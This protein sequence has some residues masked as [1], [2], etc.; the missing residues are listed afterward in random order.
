[1]KIETDMMLLRSAFLAG[2]SLIIGVAAM[3]PAH[4]QAVVIGVN[5]ANPQRLS[6]VEQDKVLDQLQA[7][8]VRVIRAPLKPAFGDHDYGAAIDFLHLAY[9]RGIKT[10]LIIGLQYRES[11]QRR[12][13]ARDMPDMW[14]SYPLSSADPIRFR[15]V[16]QPLFAQL[17]ALGIHFVSLELGNEINGTAFNGDFPIPG[18]G[19]VFGIDDLAQDP[20]ARQIAAGFLAYLQTL[21]VL[22]DIRDHSRLNRTTPIL[23][24]GLS[25]PGPAGPRP[26]SKV[27]AVTISATLDFLRANGLDTLVD[28][29]GVHAYPWADN[30]ARRLN[31]LERDTL[32][33]CRPSGQGKPCWLTEWGIPSDDTSCP[34]NDAPRTA[35]MREILA[36]FRPFA[37]RGRLKGLLYYAWTDDKYGIYRCASLA[38]SGRLVL[39]ASI[40]K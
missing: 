23:S 1:L 34:D 7:A 25:D 32:V 21:Q 14:P 6:A 26:R 18:E 4:G 37:R 27:D 39:D 10:D 40:L 5:V 24:A 2:C 22:K 29:Y 8:G 13:A 30:A 11:A 36:D 19:R 38:E 20:E 35:L 31:Q 33:E 15:A 17:E 3:S 12:P 16:I 28:A 9:M